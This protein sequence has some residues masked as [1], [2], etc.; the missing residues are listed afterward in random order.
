MSSKISALDRLEKLLHSLPEE[1]GTGLVDRIRTIDSWLEQHRNR[2]DPRLAHFL[3][4][5]SYDKALN[6]LQDEERG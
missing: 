1:Q 5:R 3:A 4:R 6:Y 2:L